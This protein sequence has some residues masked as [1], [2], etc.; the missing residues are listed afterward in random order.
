MQI[1][2]DFVLGGVALA[3]NILLKESGAEFYLAN[4]LTAMFVGV[5]LVSYGVGLRI[6]PEDSERPPFARHVILGVFFMLIGQ[7]T[8][9]T[10]ERQAG[11]KSRYSP[12]FF[13]GLTDW[14]GAFAGRGTC[15]Q[16]QKH[17]TQ[18]AKTACR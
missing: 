4:T 3:G 12:W 9:L 2:N 6:G 17:P 14:R 10:R 5:A 1:R 11:S 8:Y 13:C 7:V 18:L 15:I 16:I